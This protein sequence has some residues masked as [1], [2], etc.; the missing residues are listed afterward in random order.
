MDQ[1]E[2]GKE[3]VYSLIM[4]L[5]LA[6]EPDDALARLPFVF[7]SEIVALHLPSPTGKSKSGQLASKKFSTD[8]TRI[9]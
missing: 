3:W 6:Q 8:M 4:S 1:A 2:W 5:H 9:A 7:P